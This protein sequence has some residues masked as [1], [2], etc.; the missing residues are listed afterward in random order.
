VT[1]GKPTASDRIRRASP[2]AQPPAGRTISGDARVK[3]VRVTVDFD[4]AVYDQLRQWA[5]AERMSHADVLR[6]LV[7]LLEDPSVA[8]RVRSY[9]TTD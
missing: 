6:A 9:G 8:K 2:V 4:P 7:T 5:F 3:P 1:P